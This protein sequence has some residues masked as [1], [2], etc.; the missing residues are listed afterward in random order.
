MNS[1]STMLAEANRKQAEALEELTRQAREL[2]ELHLTAKE[3]SLFH[4]VA[5]GRLLRR[6]KAQLKHG[7]FVKWI[8]ENLGFKRA[9]AN[10]AMQA[11]EAADTLLQMSTWEDICQRVD[12]LRELAALRA[13]AAAVASGQP[14]PT[15]K[16]RAKPNQASEDAQDAE[17]AYQADVRDAV[18]KTVDTREAALIEREKR[19]G[20]ID[21]LIAENTALKAKVAELES[22]ISRLKTA[23]AELR[24]KPATRRTTK[25]DSNGLEAARKTARK[26]K[27]KPKVPEPSAPERVVVTDDNRLD[28]PEECRDTAQTY[29]VEDGMYTYFDAQDNEVG[30]YRF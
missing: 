14:W 10:V 12:S 9:W 3:N 25:D 11:S 16:P 20:D 8:E 6:V 21:A 1:L 29:T 18:D 22:E 26:G 19:L 17:A 7:Q 13:V 24:V 4:G 5:L 15:K 23:L 2:Y 27:G 28:V 30:R